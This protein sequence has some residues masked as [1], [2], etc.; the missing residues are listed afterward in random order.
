MEREHDDD[1]DLQRI[2]LV[3]VCNLAIDRHDDEENIVMIGMNGMEGALTC[4]CVEE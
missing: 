1:D 3:P 2:A 4:S